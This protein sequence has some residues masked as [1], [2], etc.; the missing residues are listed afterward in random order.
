MNFHVVSHS[1]AGKHHIGFYL[2]Y[3][4]NSYVIIYPKM[5]NP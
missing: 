5:K 1:K 2:K 3:Q 4:I